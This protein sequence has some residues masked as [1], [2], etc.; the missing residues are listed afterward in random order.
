MKLIEIF[1]DVVSQIQLNENLKNYIKFS[2]QLKKVGRTKSNVGGFQSVNLNHDE[3]TLSNL[4]NK[5]A[6]FGPDYPNNEI[7]KQRKILLE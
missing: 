1:K 2:K 3:P 5:D 7:R 4:I 6:F